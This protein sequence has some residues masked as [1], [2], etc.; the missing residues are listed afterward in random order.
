MKKCSSTYFIFSTKHDTTPSWIIAKNVQTNSPLVGNVNTIIFTKPEMV[1]HYFLQ[2][3]QHFIFYSILLPLHNRNKNLV[4]VQ[5]FTHLIVK[6]HCCTL[7]I[8][9]IWLIIN[10]VIAFLYTETGS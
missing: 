8:W 10:D 2:L 4:S 7:K 3:Q 1:D 5:P 9:L 6:A